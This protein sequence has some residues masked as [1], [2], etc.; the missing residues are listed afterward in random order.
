MP[1]NI[2]FFC[3]QDFFIGFAVPYFCCWL[4]N[5]QEFSGVG[6]PEKKCALHVADN[7]F[8]FGAHRIINSS[9]FAV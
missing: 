3:F 9:N 6:K 1:A 8:Y 2:I 5:L 4:L 7:P